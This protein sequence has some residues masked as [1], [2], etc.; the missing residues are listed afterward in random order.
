MWAWLR[1]LRN[2]PTGTSCFF[3][4]I[5][6]STTSPARR[7]NLTWLPFWLASTNPAASRRRLISRKGCGLSR[8][9]LDL[10]HAD[11]GLS[12]RSRRLEVQFQRLFQVRQGLFFGFTLAG[13]IDLQ[14]LGD[15]PLP[16]T[17]N[18]C[19]ERTRHAHILSQTPGVRLALFDGGHVARSRLRRRDQSDSIQTPRPRSPQRNR[20]AGAPPALETAG[21]H[22][23][24]HQVLQVSQRRVRGAFRKLGPF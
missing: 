19:S 13:H 8:P 9:N 3:G 22:S 11:S 17:P 23:T 7:T 12:C 24:I 20:I 5:A 4:T 16:L 6:V 21:E 10:D 1:M 14:A 15:E 2:V 18:G